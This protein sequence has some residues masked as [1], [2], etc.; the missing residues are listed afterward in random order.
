[1]DLVVHDEGVPAVTAKVTVTDGVPGAR[2]DEELGVAAEHD[3][4]VG[5][6]LAWHAAIRM[7]ALTS[8]V[9]PNN[10]LC[11]MIPF[12]TRTRKGVFS[13]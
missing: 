6:G 12:S 13:T 2:L 8:A 3:L 9:L 10:S 1:M 4:D 7:P 11:C 5:S